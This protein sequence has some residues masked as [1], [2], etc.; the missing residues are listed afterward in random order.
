MRVLQVSAALLL[1]AV[2][3]NGQEATDQTQFRAEPNTKA[4]FSGIAGGSVAFPFERFEHGHLL[5][6]DHEGSPTKPS[7]LVFGRDGKLE[8]EVVVWFPGA[9]RV[10]IGDVAITKGGR[11]VA[12]GAAAQENGA[13]A[14]FLAAFDK[15]GKMQNVVRTSPY[16]ANLICTTADE[17]TVWTFGWDRHVQSSSKHYSML[18][19]YSMEKGLR[20]ELLDRATLPVDHLLMKGASLGDVG[21]HCT[22]SAVALH[23]VQTGQLIEHRLKDGAQLTYT[24]L[25]KVAKDVR[26]TGYTMTE[27]G[28]LFAS[29]SIENTSPLTY[30]LFRLQKHNSEGQWQPV[31]G[32]LFSATKEKNSMRILGS[33]DNDVVYLSDS[34]RDAVTWA[35]MKKLLGK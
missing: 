34:A 6:W 3:C 4:I 18:R 12:T 21:L 2:I 26:V 11:L 27:D 8:R 15:G 17:E 10:N 5:A 20:S 29:M 16:V 30:G 24:K 13:I 33:E 1:L 9:V 19:E 28:E 32:M 14:D 31:D 35:H 22:S 23:I 7:I 25:P